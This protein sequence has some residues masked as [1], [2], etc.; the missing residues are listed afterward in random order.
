[1]KRLWGMVCLALVL[2][3]P[4]IGAEVTGKLA[5]VVVDGSGAA[6]PGV[7]VTIQSPS[8]IGGA[9][10]VT[11][12]ANGEF[13]FAAV[14]PG[15][16]S[17][18]AELSGLATQERS[19]V[20]VRLDRTTFLNVSMS[21]DV[22]SEEIVVTA[23]TPVVDPERVSASQNFDLEYLQNVA[24]GANNRGYQDILFQAA[25]VGTNRV[26]GS[27]PS[28]FGSTHMENAFYVDGSNTTDPLT[29]T[30]GT[31]FTFDAI[32]EVSFQTGGF[33]AEY[34]NATGGVVNVVTKS[35]GND[36]SGSLD[37]RF[38]D[39]GF[40]T[41]G[42]HFDPDSR[43]FLFND[44]AG[45]IGGPIA[46]DRAWFFGSYEKPVTD[47][48][49]SGNLTSRKFDG[50][51]YLG[52][53]TFQA[54]PSW[55]LQGQFS[56]DPAEITNSAAPNRNYSPEA[57][58]VQSQGGEIAQVYG[59]GVLGQ[60]M[61]LDFRVTQN[62]QNL[63]TVPVSGDLETPSFQNV[64]TGQFSNN[65]NNAQFSTRDRDEYRT[66]L[67][68]FTGDLAGS[69]E[70][71]GG[72]EYG[73][74]EITSSNFTTGDY[75][76]TTRLVNGAQILRNFTFNEDR[77]TTAS[78]GSITSAYVQDSWRPNS[79]L[80]LKLGA[81]YDISEW[82]NNV[83][84]EVADL[85]R[86]QPRL[87][88]AYDITGDAKTIVRANWGQF[89]HPASTRL[90]QIARVTGNSPTV[91]AFSCEYV[92]QFTFGLPPD[93]GIPCEEVAQAAHDLAGFEGSIV[94]DGL[95][96][97]PDGWIVQTIVGGG[98]PSLVDPNLK[99]TYAEELIL[100]FERQ[101]FDKTSVE[102]SYIDKKTN[103][104][105]EDTCLENIPERTENACTNFIVANMPE[106]K[107][108]YTG[109]ILKVESRALDWLR[110]LGSVTWSESQGSIEGTQYAGGDFDLYSTDFVNTYG[111]LSDDREWRFKLN[112]YAT[113]PLGFQIGFGY[114]YES[115]FPYS[116]RDR[117]SLGNT[118]EFVEPRGN[119]RA[120][121]VS[122]LDLSVSKDF[123]LGPVNLQLIGAI[124]N[125]LDAE[126]PNAVCEDING[127]AIATGTA[128]LGEATAWQQPLNYEAGIRFTF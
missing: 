109:A 112:G 99:A 19:E 43:T 71:K 68:G 23:D 3:A 75:L 115:A 61:L 83:G 21:S 88:V 105:F 126:E 51:Y 104:I 13:N 36:F 38:A 10:T 85:D 12:E 33:E 121:A 124:Y 113:L 45:T 39:E 40:A 102:V 66:S 123:H 28:V 6:L 114:L 5:G 14:P 55:Q 62:R 107:R 9:R 24:V 81:R 20:E 69:H 70:F 79:R 15:I 8:L 42:E 64:N 56:G 106:L 98:E 44:A 119:H 37:W 27:N 63:D 34:G 89:M 4:A 17:V 120:N 58:S 11:T 91:T 72:I 53:L 52:K 125:V 60:D 65:Y 73:D 46:R 92:R 49:A 78:D 16:Y 96:L 80:S 116:A 76:Y 77:S 95:G 54:T 111:F 41:E 48:E 84:T 94:Q 18:K 93:S 30:W 31:N 118:A 110:V 74:L 108:D 67:T 82:A 101:I 29:E 117:T 86:L 90:G 26:S 32:Q 50:E 59:T 57:Q 87:G 35:G 127:C 128:E 7:S 25:G 47:I 97:D 122:Q 2:A 22:V 103:D 100:S 1:M